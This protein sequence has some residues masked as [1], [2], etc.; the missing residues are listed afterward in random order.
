MTPRKT[1]LPDDVVHFPGG[2]LVEIWRFDGEV[3]F[4]ASGG[5]YRRGRLIVVW[6]SGDRSSMPRWLQR[7]QP[8]LELKPVIF[9]VGYARV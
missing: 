3:E 2:D 1:L 6:R 4:G 7:P 8:L 5:P 9:N